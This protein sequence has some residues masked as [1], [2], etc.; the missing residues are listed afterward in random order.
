VLAVFSLLPAWIG[1]AR[2]LWS[3]AGPLLAF[4]MMALALKFAFGGG[5]IAARKLF[6]F[7]LLYL[8]AAFVVL[9]IAWRN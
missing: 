8:P 2:V 3:V 9:L 7:T 1:F 6:L 5:R 4:L